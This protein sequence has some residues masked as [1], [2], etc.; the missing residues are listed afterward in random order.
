[1][2][3]VCTLSPAFLGYAAGYFAPGRK[4]PDAAFASAYHLKLGHGLA[5]ERLRA[6]GARNV[7]IVLNIIPTVTDDP[8]MEPATRYVDGI[9]NR[10]WLD[11][12]AGRG[13]PTDLREGCSELTDWAFVHDDDL[14]IIANPIDWIGENYYSISRVVSVEQAGSAAIG[15]DSF[16]RA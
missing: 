10:L 11:L 5:V 16:S 2:C 3:G 9:Q 6:A 12:L 4:D 13:I 15:Q 7:G 14:A 8:M 1:M